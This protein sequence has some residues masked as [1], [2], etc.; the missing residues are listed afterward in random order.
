VKIRAMWLTAGFWAMG[1][2]LQAGGQTPRIIQPDL[3]AVAAGKVWRVVNRQASVIR[4]DGKVVVRLDER[5]GDGAAWLEGSKFAT[6]TIELEIRGKDLF[7]RSFVGV[8]FHGADDQT[9][10]AVYFR[11]FNFRS[12]EPARRSHAVQYISQPENTWQKLRSEQPGRFEQAVQPVPDPTGWFRARIEVTPSRVR[13]LV[14]GAAQPSLDV[15]R[16]TD[17]KTG[18]IGF[19]VGNGSGGDFANLRVTPQP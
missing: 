2:L 17:R 19:W 13:V 10:E 8:A 18:L 16:L 1:F 9:Y 14:D 15:P 11:P 12:T 4:E 5:V 6:G 3:T 7:Q